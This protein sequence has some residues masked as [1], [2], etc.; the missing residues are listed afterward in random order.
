MRFQSKPK[1]GFAVAK[2]IALRGKKATVIEQ[3]KKMGEAERILWEE[4]ERMRSRGP[5]G[6]RGPAQKKRRV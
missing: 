2:K 6:F 3:T 4:L 5:S 1:K